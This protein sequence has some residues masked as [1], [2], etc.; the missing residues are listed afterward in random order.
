VQFE[1]ARGREQRQRF[2]VFLQLL[3]G[4][5][6]G[7]A[8]AATTATMPML[9]RPTMSSSASAAPATVTTAAATVT[10]ISVI[11]TATVSTAAPLLLRHTLIPAKRE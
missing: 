9:T 2:T 5:A 7:W 8:L 10:V 4:S 11:P 3:F 1:H 6:S